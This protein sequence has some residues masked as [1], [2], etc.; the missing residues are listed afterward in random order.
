MITRAT[1]LR[2]LCF[3]PLLG[4]AKRLPAVEP[5]SLVCKPLQDGPI[6]GYRADAIMID[7]GYV[8]DV[9]Q[10]IRDFGRALMRERILY[11]NAYVECD[12]RAM[13]MTLYRMTP[14]GFYPIKTFHA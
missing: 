7:D 9:E 14:N 13:L 2:S 10:E 6:R 12:E 11:G 3:L 5:K 4:L 1:F 8:R